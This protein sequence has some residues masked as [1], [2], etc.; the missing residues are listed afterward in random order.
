MECHKCEHRED[1]EAGKYARTPFGRTPC[2]KCELVEVSTRTVEVDVSRP[3]FRPGRDNPGMVYEVT[4]DE[5]ES[6]M[7]Q[8]RL[9]V[10]VMEEF[11]ER[12]L[13]LPDELR[14]VVCWRFSGLTYPEIGRRQGITTAGAEAR[15]RRAMRMF[16]ELEDLFI[17]K[18]VQHRL[19]LLAAQEV[20]EKR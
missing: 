6:D 20:L 15:H 8:V 19:R 9:P 14:D 3:V 1:V 5:E 18:T 10:G 16:P 11:V 2:S 17:A 4:S 13:K 12:L 7:K